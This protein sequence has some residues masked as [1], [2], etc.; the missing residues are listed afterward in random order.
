LWRIRYNWRPVLTQLSYAIAASA[1]ALAV[2]LSSVSM[3]LLFH[4]AL[5]AFYMVGVWGA[6]VLTEEERQE[7]R[8]GGRR[9]VGLLRSAR[10]S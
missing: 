9:L 4:A 8:Q 5:F 1:V 2:P 10:A 7:L 3:S 6:G